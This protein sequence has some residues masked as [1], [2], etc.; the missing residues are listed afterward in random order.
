MN[1]DESQSPNQDP[2][3]KPEPSPRAR[4]RPRTYWWAFAAGL[5]VLLVVV[6]LALTTL[7]G[8]RAAE[9]KVFS[10]INYGLTNG[11]ASYADEEA[12][13]E[14]AV[15]E[16][17][18][19]GAAAPIAPPPPPAPPQPARRADDGLTSGDA[20][21]EPDTTEAETEAEAPEGLA[22]DMPAGEETETEGAVLPEATPADQ[23]REPAEVNP[24]VLTS[25]DHLSTFA[26]DVDT[27]SYAAARNYLNDGRLPPPGAV[28]VEEFVNYFDYGY[29]EPS[30]DAFGISVDAAPSPWPTGNDETHLVRVG[31]QGKHL[32]DRERKD[33]VLTFVIDISGSMDDP[34]RLPLVKEALRLLVD[35]L[36]PTDQVAIVVYSDDT[37]AVLDYTSAE[38]GDTIMQAIDALATEG[39]T[40]VE[41]GLKLAYQMAGDH[42]E[43]EAVNRVI[44][45]SDGVANVGATGPDAIRQVIRDYTAQGVYLT[46]VGFGMGDYNDY[47]M[48]QLADDGN[49]NYAYV[50]TLDEAHRVFVENLTGLLQVIARDAKVQV[51]FNPDVVSRYRLLGYE[52]RDVA[53]EDFRNDTVDAGE[54]G[55]GHSVTALY[56]MVL[57]GQASGPALTVSL[58]YEDPETGEVHELAHPFDRGEML[59]SLEEAPPNFQLAVAVAGFAEHLRESGPAQDRSLDDILTIAERAAAQFG[60]AEDHEAVQEFVRL[61][62]RA[63][64]L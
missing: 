19:G 34:R 61:V 28:R 41:D 46:T 17:A 40:N 22:A 60:N 15:L 7:L 3:Q 1:M 20:L 54:I 59:P 23:E 29:P 42:F 35:E 8:G 21:V 9:N 55:A 12:A 14:E 64:E 6:L 31:I 52:N 5:A 26:L 36:R 57:T 48:E 18:Q 58:R 25:E 27:A 39:S 13:E 56:E 44:L 45:C 16:E 24:F 53:D 11:D 51:D 4:F 30:Q 62:R 10:Q 43:V 32:D 2:S 50:D 33:A 63:S 49:G 38:N 37:R 47:L